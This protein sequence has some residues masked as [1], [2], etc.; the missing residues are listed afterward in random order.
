MLQ[1]IEL[2]KITLYI[3]IYHVANRQ[4]AN[5]ILLYWCCLGIRHRFKFALA[6]RN[7]KRRSSHIRAYTLNIVFHFIL[8]YV[9]VAYQITLLNV[10]FLFSLLVSFRFTQSFCLFH[11]FNVHSIRGY[12]NSVVILRHSTQTESHLVWR[13]SN[14]VK[15]SKESI[16]NIC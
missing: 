6:T 12:F 13:F 7:L 15:K 2:H 8:L 16:K 9:A 14:T 4:A 1:P 3:N 11:C 5:V 10:L